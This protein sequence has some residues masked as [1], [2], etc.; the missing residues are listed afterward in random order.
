MA[1]PAAR[2]IR[3]SGKK[4]PMVLDLHENYPFT[5]N[6]YNWTKGFLRRM[7][8]RPW[9]W[10]EKEGEYLNYADRII[11]LS[12]NYRDE[13]V[14]GYPSLKSDK[15]CVMPNVPD[16]DEMNSYPVDVSKL[17]FQKRFPLLFYFGIVA[18]RRGIFNALDAFRKMV[19]NGTDIG[20]LIIGPVDKHDKTRFNHYLND[21][22]I[23]KRIIYIPWIDLSELNTYLSVSDI[24]IAPFI[25]NPQHESG[26]AN[27]IYDYM[28]GKKPLVVSD[29][30]PQMELVQKYNCGLAYRNEDEL[31]KAIEALLA[32]KELREQMGTNGYNAIIN[33]LNLVIVKNN[34]ISLY[35]DINSGINR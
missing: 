26:V 9:R 22:K 11:V 12:E 2:A 6:T 29:C 15:F 31:I 33:D 1:G 35:R 25:K 19:T 30:K 24:C 4:I 13:L 34:L 7:L 17:V 21:E 20:F 10:K 27:K 28:L 14:S 32:N 3:Q 16:I 18:E 8:S 5:V 23:N